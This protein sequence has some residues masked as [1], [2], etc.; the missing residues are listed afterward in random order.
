MPHHGVARMGTSRPLSLL[1]HSGD[2]SHGHESTT[3]DGKNTWTT[4]RTRNH[5]SQERQNPNG[6]QLTWLGPTAN[7]LSIV[8]AT[9]QWMVTTRDVSCPA[10]ACE[11]Y[12]HLS[13]QCCG[14]EG[15]PRVLAPPCPRPA[16][17]P[18]RCGMCATITVLA[19]TRTCPHVLPRPIAGTHAHMLF[20]QAAA[21]AP[22]EAAAAA[23][24]T[25]Q[26][27]SNSDRPWRIP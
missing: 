21:A 12:C 16:L 23:S 10:D 20:V 27:S 2:H 1:T 26:G 14:Y 25:P 9:Q 8:R 7:T 24:N 18:M 19:R 5:R 6:M 22:Q 3:L 11:S 17:A 13:V 15:I 4:S